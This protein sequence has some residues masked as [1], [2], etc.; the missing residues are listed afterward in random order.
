[1]SGYPLILVTGSRHYR[2]RATVISVLLPYANTFG[3]AWL[4][5]GD[6][7]GLDR[8][9]A[10]IWNQWHPGQFEAF[11]ADWATYGNRAG[12]LRNAAMVARKPAV[13][14]GFPLP[15]SRGTYGCMKL[16]REA[17]ILTLEVKP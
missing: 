9:A 8:L 3:N 11:P 5:H 1:M 4:L 13:C 10:S 15:D 16:A 17:G 7:D 12:P 6:C 14:I 2:D